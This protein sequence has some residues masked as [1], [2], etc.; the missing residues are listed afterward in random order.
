MSALLD[1]LFAQHKRSLLWVLRRIVR[2]QQAAEDLAQET[3]LKTHQ[4]LANRRIEH[5]EQYIFQTARNLALDHN[6]RNRFRGQFYHA[7]V[8]DEK[9]Q[10]IPYDAPNAEE[11]TIEC[12]RRKLFEKALSEL[13]LRAR[14][15]WALSYVEELTYQEIA[16]RLG[17]S[18][19]TVYND[20]K[21]VIGY[22]RDYLERF[23][24]N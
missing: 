18:R 21:L 11:N 19:N 2:D 15:A 5:L 23:E 17:V 20:I 7:D 4:A 10:N 14:E 22:C 6:R 24:N 12:E 8:S 9:L 1:A 16:D 13:P 3:Y